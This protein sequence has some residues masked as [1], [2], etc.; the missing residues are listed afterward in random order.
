[1]LFTRD[2]VGAAASEL[3]VTSEARE[4]VHE[5]R[6]WLTAQG[7]AYR[8]TSITSEASLRSYRA[9]ERWGVKIVFRVSIHECQRTAAGTHFVSSMTRWKRSDECMSL[10]LKLMNTRVEVSL[11]LELEEDIV[12]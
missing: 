4:L 5:W 1:M 7:N 11:E 10:G 3:S 6:R 8:C 2:V 12:C 9:T